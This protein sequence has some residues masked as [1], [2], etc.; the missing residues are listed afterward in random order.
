MEQLKKR[1]KIYANPQ[2]KVKHT[3]CS[4]PRIKQKQKKTELHWM[5]QLQ[6]AS[7]PRLVSPKQNK[8]KIAVHLSTYLKLI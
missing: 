2:L 5:L 7:K 1:T 3:N 6:A 8:S 4:A